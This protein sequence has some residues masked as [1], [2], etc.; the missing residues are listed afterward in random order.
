[1]GREAG[2]IPVP[3]LGPT[4][5]RLRVLRIK[6]RKVRSTPGRVQADPLRT[7]KL[8]L[9]RTPG[10]SALTIGCSSSTISLSEL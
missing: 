5:P 3:A 6:G 10:D 2:F 1:M 8:S 9:S 7:R 4:L